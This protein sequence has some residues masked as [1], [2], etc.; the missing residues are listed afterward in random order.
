MKRQK[1]LDLRCSTTNQERILY[2]C[3]SKIKNNPQM[4]QADTQIT[5]CK[6]KFNT[7]KKKSP[8]LQHSSH[9]VQHV[10][11]LTRLM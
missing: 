2:I 11:K 8:K 7:L 1:K 5:D 10:T 9:D 3:P 4:K 6:T